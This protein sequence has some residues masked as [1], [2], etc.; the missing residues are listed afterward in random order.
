MQY[1]N[2]ALSTDNVTK[3]FLIHKHSKK[4]VLPISTLRNGVTWGRERIKSCEGGWYTLLD[5][6][7]Y[8]KWFVFRIAEKKMNKK[9]C[10]SNLKFGTKA[11]LK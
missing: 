5:L 3:D 10:V 6:E 11:V 1:V 7:R 9:N 4:N 8:C 2:Q